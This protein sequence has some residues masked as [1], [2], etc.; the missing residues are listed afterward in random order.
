MRFTLIQKLL[1]GKNYDNKKV[2]VR[3]LIKFLKKHGIRR[4]FISNFKKYPLNLRYETI[5][6]LCNDDIA[7][8]DWIRLAFRW[9]ATKE[10][11]EYWETISMEWIQYLVDNEDIKEII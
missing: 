10:G 11:K 8:I 9:N 3:T 5:A 4:A 7:P 6:E 2:N 1:L